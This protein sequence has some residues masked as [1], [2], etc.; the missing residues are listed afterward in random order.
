MIKHLPEL[1]ITK[2]LKD[3]KTKGEKYIKPFNQNFDNEECTKIIQGYLLTYC[4]EDYGEGKYQNVLSI[5]N[6]F[7]GNSPI[8]IKEKV[9]HDIPEIKEVFKLLADGEINF[10]RNFTA[11]GLTVIFISE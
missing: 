7:K 11:R 5:S 8:K 2:K 3:L 4:K 1:D 10:I 6:N 9:L